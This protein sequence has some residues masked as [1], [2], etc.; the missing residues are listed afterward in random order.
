MI[1]PLL[2]AKSQTWQ[3]YSERFVQPIRVEAGAHWERECHY[4]PI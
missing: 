1:S 2:G 3:T 4:Q